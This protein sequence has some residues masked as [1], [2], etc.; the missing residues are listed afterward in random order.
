ML[1]SA[2]NQEGYCEQKTREFVEELENWGWDCGRGSSTSI[3]A[4]APA[5]PAVEEA[6]MQVDA[7]ATPDDTEALAPADADTA[8]DSMN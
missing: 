4:E 6:D 8:D 7:P 5:E 1:W 2:S 3:D